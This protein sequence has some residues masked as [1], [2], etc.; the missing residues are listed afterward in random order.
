MDA[1]IQ[2]TNLLLY[3]AKCVLFIRCTKQNIAKI[4]TKTLCNN[5]L[6]LQLT[7]TLFPFFNPR[8]ANKFKLLTKN[9]EPYFAKYSRGKKMT[10]QLKGILLMGFP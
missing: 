8:S 1:K 3:T 4:L 5:I 9:Y 2:Y 7:K 10:A 6:W